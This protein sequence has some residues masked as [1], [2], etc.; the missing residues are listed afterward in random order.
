MTQNELVKEL[1]RMLDTTEES[2]EGRIFHPITFSCCR[3]LM[4]EPFGRILRELKESI[5][6]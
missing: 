3:S 2:D 6:P 1:F 4:T 5:V